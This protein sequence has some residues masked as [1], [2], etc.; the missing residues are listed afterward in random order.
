MTVPPVDPARSG[1]VQVPSDSDERP[2]IIADESVRSTAAASRYEQV[3]SAIDDEL[4]RWRELGAV[5]KCD[6][7]VALAHDLRPR[8]VVEV[9]AGTGSLLRRLSSLSFASAYYAMEVSPSAI[10]F[11]R[12]EA[13][14]PGL[15]GIYLVDSRRTGLPDDS[16]DLGI[17]SHVLEHV[18]DPVGV[19]RETLRICRHVVVEVPLEDCLIANLDWTVR[20][21]A[22]G[23]RRVENVSGH[24]HF[25]NP[26]SIRG[27]IE[28]AGGMV[29]RERRFF[30]L[31]ATT[32]FGKTGLERARLT[33]KHRVF[34]LVFRATASRL[35]ISFFGALVAKAP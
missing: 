12:S 25:F 31:L 9:G 27:T 4:L 8:T 5:Q 24:I 32:V 14:I 21:R 16:F 23:Q 30:P 28:A 10:E 1:R 17:L 22:L 7:I 20:E 35:V 34:E 11:L 13:K 19:L 3:Y 15:E 2:F 33:A 6:D 26:D 18:E 29:A